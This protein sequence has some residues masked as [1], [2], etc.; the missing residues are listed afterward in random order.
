MSRRYITWCGSLGGLP[1]RVSYPKRRT[2][3]R[4]LYPFSS[5]SNSVAECCLRLARLGVRIRGMVPAFI[6]KDQR[7]R[8]LSSLPLISARWRIRPK[9]RSDKFRHSFLC[10]AHSY[11]RLMR[12][13][14]DELVLGRL[15][16]AISLYLVV[17]IASDRL[18][19]HRSPGIYHVRRPL[20]D[21]KV[22]CRS[23][24]LNYACSW[25]AATV[26]P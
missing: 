13:K 5:R 7:E 16:T 8:A 21:I 20:A 18:S 4:R 1:F 6:T 25:L 3:S 2:V 23:T 11:E 24:A 17:R 10:A 22:Y 19:E 9:I 14:W 12:A 15:S 26:R